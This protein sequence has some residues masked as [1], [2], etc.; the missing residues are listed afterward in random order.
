MSYQPPRI[1][2]VGISWLSDVCTTRKDPE[3]EWL[4]RDHLETNPITTRP[5]TVS[6]MA[7]R[8]SWVPLPSCSPPGC[9]FPVKSLANFCVYPWTI[10][11]WM[12]DKS[13]LSGPRRGPLSCNRSCSERQLEGTDKMH[14]GDLG[15]NCRPASLPEN[16]GNKQLGRDFLGSEQISP[17]SFAQ[18]LS[19]HEMNLDQL[20]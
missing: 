17:S 13:P 18:M 2:L 14:I 8:S 16:W 10:H 11:F 20:I 4:A 1:L 6:H 5:K 15:F 3:S 9:P 19:S 7:Q 12:L